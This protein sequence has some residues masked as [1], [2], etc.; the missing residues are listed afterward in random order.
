MAHWSLTAYETV[1]WFEG[2]DGA[3]EWWSVATY[4]AAAALASATARRLR[5]SDQHKLAL[6]HFFLAGVFLLGAL[7]E[8]SW[9]QGLFNWGTPDVLSSVNQQDETTIHNV[10]SFDSVISRLLFW[11]SVV[12]LVSGAVRAVW[13]RY[14]R[15]TSADFVWP[16]LVLSPALLMILVWRMGDIWT[17]VNLP[18]LTMEAFDFG[19]QGSEVPEV[20]LGLCIC[21]YTYSNFRRATQLV[22]SRGHLEEKP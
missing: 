1:D 16:S 14:G 22:K 4:L 8:I 11:A 10:G 19:P 9:G 6:L 5:G 18:R 12:A 13:H 3:S 15:V 17:P 21:I 2:E 7:E 20:L